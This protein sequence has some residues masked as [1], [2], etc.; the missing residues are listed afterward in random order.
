MDSAATATATI[1]SSA[2]AAAA[3]APLA[4]TG[5]TPAVRPDAP[6]APDLRDPKLYLNRELSHLEFNARVLSLARDPA[7]PLLERLRFLTIASTNLDQFFEIRV[8]GLKQ[9]VG[10]GSLPAGPDGWS[11][12]EQLVR[13]SEVAHKMVAEQYQV[14]D[15]PWPM[16]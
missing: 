7:A 1:G 4:T 6:P 13:I 8:A 11:P 14:L 16:L 15:E 5:A 3:A 2:P 10:Y 9:Q 12:G